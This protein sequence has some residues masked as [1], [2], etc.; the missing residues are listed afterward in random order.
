[1]GYLAARPWRRKALR[2]LRCYLAGNERS[3]GV[4]RSVIF[5]VAPLRVRVWRDVD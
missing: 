2:G 4:G 1:V 5:T 3:E